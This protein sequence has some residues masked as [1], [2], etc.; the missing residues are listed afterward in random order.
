MKNEDEQHELGREGFEYLKPPRKESERTRKPAIAP[1]G[2]R[3]FLCRDNTATTA[4][5]RKEKTHQ[6][7]LTMVPLRA[8][9]S[10][11]RF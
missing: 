10:M 11:L 3:D 5:T 4:P 1:E 9:Q 2:E 7:K 8:Q 6:S